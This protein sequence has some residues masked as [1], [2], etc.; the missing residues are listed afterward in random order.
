M[1]Q[2]AIEDVVGV[3]ASSPLQ[4]LMGSQAFWVTLAVIIIGIVMSFVSPV[5]ASADNMFN[6][7]RN[8]AFIG[9][10]ALGMTA[11][12]I[13]AG[14]DLSVGSVMGISG[15]ITALV[16]QAGSPMW[17]GITAGFWQRVSSSASSTAR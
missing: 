10:I 5:F 3:R 11:V 15:I 16:L 6:V 17:L 8:F 4:K 2:V 13:T 9:I 12:I 1:S 14:I 7:T